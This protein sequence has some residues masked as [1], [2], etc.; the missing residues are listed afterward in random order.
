MYVKDLQIQKRS[1]PLLQIVVQ[2]CTSNLH[3][4]N[5]LETD[6][7]SSKDYYVVVW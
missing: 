4:Q 2:T 7:P 3:I 1:Y 5:I 6:V